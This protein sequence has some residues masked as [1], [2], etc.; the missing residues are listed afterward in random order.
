MFDALESAAGCPGVDPTGDPRRPR[1]RGLGRRRCA[2]PG[3]AGPGGCWPL[4]GPCPTRPRLGSRPGRARR[5]GRAA[6]RQGRPP[7]RGPLAAAAAGSGRRRVAGRP[8]RGHRAAPRLLRLDRAGPRRVR[9]VPAHDRGRARARLPGTRRERRRAL[10]VRPPRGRGR[11]RRARLARRARRHPGRARRVRRWA[12][13]PPSPRSPCSAT[14]RSPRPMPT[15]LPPR[16]SGR[17]AA[18]ADRRG[19]RRLGRAR[20]G[21]VPIANR[22]RGPARRFTASRLFDGAA[23]MLGADPRATEPARIVALV[24]PIPLLLIH[25]GADTTVPLADGPSAGGA[26]RPARRAL[27][28]PGRGAQPAPTPSPPQ[29]YER[30][31]TDFL[32]VAF[33]AARG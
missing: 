25:G 22:L 24:E 5:R 11:G 27:G 4:R 28:G 19:G 12:G 29:D 7:A 23:D 3:D 14:A 26:R 17:C 33:Q 20:A 1:G 21:R 32:R 10:D 6:A 15:R 31:V 18:S 9:A 13:S 30:R 2:W 16:A 8:A